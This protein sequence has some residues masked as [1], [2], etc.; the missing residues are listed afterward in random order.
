MRV[1]RLFTAPGVAAR[2]VVFGLLGW[3]AIASGEAATYIWANTTGNWSDGANW[4]NGTAPPADDPL[5]SLTFGGD[6]G[7]VLFPTPYTST[8][9]IGTGSFLLNAITLQATG[10]AP[11]KPAHVIAAATPANALLFTGAS[12]QIVQIGSGAITFTTPIQSTTTLAFAGSGTGQVTLNGPVSGVFDIVKSGSSVYRFGSAGSGIPSPNTWVG[13]L[14]IN[15]GVIRFN[16]NADTGSTAL[17]SNPVELNSPT[18][19]LILRLGSNDPE[20]S[21][22]L[23]TLSGAAGLVEARQADA[24][25]TTDFDSVD[26]VITA[27]QNG[28]Y[29]G[30][31]RNTPTGGGGSGGDFVVR[32]AAT[33]TFTGLLEIAKDVAVGHGATMELAGNASLGGQ[34]AGAL[35][36]NGGSVVLN[37]TSFSN[38]N[39]LRDG[40]VTST[41]VDTIGGGTLSLIGNTAGSSETIG[42]L[43]LGSPTKSRSGAVTL[44]VTHNAGVNASTNLFLK[45]YSRDMSAV[46]QT[47]TVNFTARDGAGTIPLGQPG[48]N[49]HIF[50]GDFG[51]I[52]PTSNGLLATTGGV[53]DVG[54]ATVNGSD[55]ASYDAA[56]GV[57]AV[58]TVPLPG[59][60][61]DATANVELTGDASI[62]PAVAA[63][64]I[65]SLKLAPIAPGGDLTVSPAT[66]LNTR[67]IVLGGAEDFSIAGGGT[68][69]TGQSNRYIHVAKS[70]L[71]LDLAID[72]G[73][74]GSTGALVKSGGGTLA[75]SSV[76]NATSTT[77]TVINE[78]VVRASAS[79]LPGGELRFRGGVLE[80]AG[81]GSFTRTLGTGAG[82]VN[83]SG[84]DPVALAGIPEDRGSGGFAAIGGDATVTIGGAIPTTLYWEDARFLHSGHALILGS[85]TAD[86]RLDFTNSIGLSTNPA[87]IV[88]QNYNARE[89]L[90]NDNPAST[91]DVARMSGVISGGV[92]NDLLKTGAGT[93]ELSNMGNTYTGA[94]IVH[95]G[96][97]LVNGSITSSFLT[98]VRPGGTLSGRGHV[99]PVRVAALGTLAP[100]IVPASASVLTV[101]TLKLESNA[102]FSLEL[103]GTTALPD[104][105]TNYDQVRVNGGITLTGAVLEGSLLNG[106]NPVEGDKFFVMLNDGIDPVTGAFA[107]AAGELTFG[108][109]R[110]AVNYADNDPVNGDGGFNDISLT[111]IPEPA[112]LPL[113]VTVG[114]ALSFLSRRRRRAR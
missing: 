36:L 103:G 22:R 109:A 87:L 42:R 34:A 66:T 68:F 102:R 98:D 77:R 63:Y 45:S 85:R 23:G 33:Q 79:S 76:S 60:V 72:P 14:T 7:T 104:G 61:G 49:P 58:V 65:N 24:T 2:V 55:F 1:N 26:I 41:G 86:S 110:F 51:F 54:W 81:G 27:L 29:G 97:L 92:Y 78:G 89:I 11:D 44:N 52:V 114:T 18:A 111:V 3:F 17:R 70:T 101:G 106:F 38:S 31:V 71:F 30:T 19:Q 5:T 25:V 80:I 91:T 50:I 43:Q 57:K 88:D 28:T 82:Q 20:S 48:N 62:D 100:G 9:N 112:A 6:V 84:F 4:T 15:D 107:N 113:L 39:R 35:V 12:P 90:V 83:W 37:N 46:T 59:G 56:S 8:N 73:L 93:L 75:L 94:T 96:T 40:T 10:A 32:G 21:L 67:G 47:T 74:A 105:T 95:E 108:G 13:N 99:G 16:N 53:T 64:T 69:T